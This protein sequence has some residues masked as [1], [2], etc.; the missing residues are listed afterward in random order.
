MKNARLEWYQST[1]RNSKLD[2]RGF[3]TNTDRKPRSYIKGLN[4]LSTGALGAWAE[5]TAAAWLIK[6][7]Y[8]VFRNIS[9]VGAVD[10]ITLS[11]SGEYESIDVKSMQHN[12]DGSNIY[13]QKFYLTKKQTE[14]GIKLLL[15]CTETGQCGF[16]EEDFA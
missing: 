1:R 10:L 12:T 8:G 11:P 5:V 2:E 3:E 6:R 16:T 14:R 13:Y 7:G 4:K 9:P 15:V